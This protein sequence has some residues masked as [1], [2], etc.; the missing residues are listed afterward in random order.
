MLTFSLGLGGSCSR[1]NTKIE[2]AKKKV[3]SNLY[4]NLKRYFF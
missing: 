3:K 2:L 1:L 4:S